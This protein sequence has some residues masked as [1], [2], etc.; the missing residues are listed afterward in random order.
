VKK[1]LIISPFFPPVNAADMHRVRQSV[2]YYKENGWDAEVVV[3]DA[4][5][6]NMVKDDLLLDSI[7]ADIKIHKVKAFDEKVTRKFGLGSIAYR[8]MYYYWKFANQLL[9]KTK[10]D[11][12]FFS[13]TAYPITILGRFW[14]WK[15]NIPYIIDMQDPW[16]SDH[17][18]SLPS[19]QRPPKF[20]LSYRLDS[21]FE[22]LAMSKVD[23]LMSVSQNYI[24]VLK[25][26]Y[27]NLNNIPSKVIPFAAFP[28]DI[29]ISKNSS[30]KNNFF[31]INADFAN[32]VYANTIFLKAIRKGIDLYPEL[33]NIR[34]YYIGTSY[35][36]SGNGAK[37]ILPIA[38]KLGLDNI[39][40][41]HTSRIPY[42]ESLKVLS[43]ASILFVP[44]SDNI[45]YTASKIYPYVW[46]NKPM[47]TLFH[48]SSS[49]NTFM[50]ECNAGIS[51][52][53]DNMNEDDIIDKLVNYIIQHKS[54]EP[55][56]ETNWSAFEKYTS[57]FQVKSQVELFNDVVSHV[58]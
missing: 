53:F 8:S 34:L 36:A 54:G 49:V 25:S 46:F 32:I 11:L 57:E 6:V 20:W 17:Y 44:G 42:F 5:Y 7:P 26:R 35:D 28:K 1:V 52:Q 45:G 27:K 21:F 33:S 30:S 39:L 13:T 31:D 4:A 10:Y 3:V 56:A 15:F 48:S 29:E 38:Q 58:S 37:T 9:S 40:L 41:E 43:E 23:G 47:I 22:K 19:N 16:R 18:L 14:K 55:G 24:D 50:K 51:L 12:V 2:S